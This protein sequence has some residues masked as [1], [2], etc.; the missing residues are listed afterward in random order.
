MSKEG[1]GVTEK[2]EE[3]EVNDNG[4]EDKREAGKVKGQRLGRGKLEM[5]E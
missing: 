4:H 5:A 3:E 2:N 1:T